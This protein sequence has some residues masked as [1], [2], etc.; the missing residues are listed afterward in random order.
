[1][2]TFLARL[3]FAVFLSARAAL[4]R[5]ALGANG[6]VLDG[7]GRVLLVRHGYQA[8]WQLPG[9]GVDGGETPDM[10]IRRELAE[11][12]GLTGGVITLVGHYFRT[13]FWMTNVIVLYRIDGG[14]IDFRP[15][16]E[17]RE[18][19]WADPASPPPDTTPATRRRLAELAGAPRSERW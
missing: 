17:I 19:C 5:I 1:M 18:I 14:V 6:L 8:G 7:D 15:S 12:V 2:S 11:E 16:L 10:A 3:V 13:A 9:G 4:S